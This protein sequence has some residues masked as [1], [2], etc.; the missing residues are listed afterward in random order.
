[1]KKLFL[2]CG[3]AL[4]A[5]SSCSKDE[6]A[7]P[8]QPQTAGNETTMEA[9][10]K[11]MSDYVYEENEQWA[12][13][14]TAEGAEELGISQA[15]YALYLENINKENQKIQ[16]MKDE[17]KGVLFAKPATDTR[18][19]NFNKSWSCYPW[20][21]TINTSNGYVLYAK[22]NSYSA[23]QA[24]KITV[25]TGWFSLGSSFTIFDGST[26]TIYE[27]YLITNGQSY[28]SYP[29]GAR[30]FIIDTYQYLSDINYSLQYRLSYNNY[31]SWPYPQPIFTLS[32]DSSITDAP[33]LM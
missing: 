1:M 13:D 33:T 19:G 7:E 21:Q 3:I 4:M 31:G 14:L 29:N 8:Q 26:A 30:E 20:A 18:A 28:I 23:T 2:M 12:F 11:L 9:D 27:M 16:K 10:F 17:G 15:N 22:P 6:I 25:N 5:L 24:V 32:W